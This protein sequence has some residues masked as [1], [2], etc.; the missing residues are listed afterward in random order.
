V[1]LDDAMRCADLPSREARAHCLGREV[2]SDGLDFALANV[3]R[4][5]AMALRAL[6]PGGADEYTDAEKRDLARELDAALLQL[7]REMEATR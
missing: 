7:G 1:S 5:G 4:I 3:A 6:A 2:A